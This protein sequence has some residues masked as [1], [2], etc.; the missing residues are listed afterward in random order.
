MAR[1]NF[2]LKFSLK[3]TLTLTFD[4]IISTHVEDCSVIHCVLLNGNLESLQNVMAWLKFFN[5]VFPKVILTLI[6]ILASDL[7]T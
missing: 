2:S 5:E 7:M 3:V 4:L 6:M 1:L